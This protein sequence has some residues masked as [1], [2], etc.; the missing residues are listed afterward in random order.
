MR[1]DAIRREELTTV[2]AKTFAI[3]LQYI[4]PGSGN[5][6]Y[7][8]VVLVRLVSQIPSTI[9]LLFYYSLQS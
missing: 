4:V 5:V 7:N 8:I 3:V 2:M 1:T 9:E 6:E